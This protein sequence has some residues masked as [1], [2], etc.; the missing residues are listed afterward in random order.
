MSPAL[1]SVTNEKED[2]MFQE[3]IQS[4][5]IQPSSGSLP[6]NIGPTPNK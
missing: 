4:H 6:E 5:N 2:A 1:D 3:L